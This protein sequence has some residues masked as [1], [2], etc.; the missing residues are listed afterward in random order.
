MTK[1][2]THKSGT[3]TAVLRRNLS[4]RWVFIIICLLV[5]AAVKADEPFRRHRENVFYAL[6]VKHKN[7]VFIGNSITNMHE[8]REAFGSQLILNRGV[9]GAVSDEVLRNI[10]AYISGKPR[11]IFLMIGIN[12]FVGDRLNDPVH[13]F[14]NVRKI[15]RYIQKASPRSEL[16]VQS[17]LPSTRQKLKLST[18]EECNRLIADYCKQADVPF[19]DLYHRLTDIGVSN[20]EY[21]FDGL[22]PTAKS[23]SIWC[24]AIEPYI[25]LRTIYPDASGIKPLSNGLTGSIGMRATHFSQF[26]IASTDVLFIGDEL[27]HSGEWAELLGNP[28]VK[29][30]G[31]GWGYAAGSLSDI[32]KEIVPIF[33]NAKGKPAKIFLYGGTADLNNG[34]VP[35]ALEKYRQVIV[36]I[37]R[38]APHT[39]LYLMAVIP[40][41]QAQINKEKYE[42]FNKGL[43]AMALENA[44]MEYID[45]Y[46]PFLQGGAANPAYITDN[47]LYGVGYAKMA[48]LLAPYVGRCKPISEAKARKNITRNRQL[49]ASVAD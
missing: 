45:T 36:G 37:R 33:H 28:N 4:H 24:H 9:S 21:T 29:N 14:T 41:A 7:I 20:P 31:T 22:H 47:M 27:I 34:T 46:T 35:A 16:Y 49:S 12:D 8:W 40:N 26:P 39:K 6:P 42:V 1:H 44:D 19:I 5:T 38:Q 25:G 18:I 43:Q 48:T 15:I 17:I 3:M 23:Y 2:F 10:A 11:K 13:T 30:R 32:S